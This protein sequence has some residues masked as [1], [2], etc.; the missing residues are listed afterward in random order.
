MHDVLRT[1]RL[2]GFT[3]LSLVACGGDDDPGDGGGDGSS[4]GSTTTGTTGLSMTDTS[5]ASASAEGDTTTGDESSGTTDE[6][7]SSSGEPTG[8]KADGETCLSSSECVSG[9]CF[10]I[11]VG[12][13]CGECTDSSDCDGGGCSPA[14]PFVTPPTPSF[15]NELLAGD[16]CDEMVT[17]SGDLSCIE[18]LDVPNVATISTCSECET[19]DDC[20]GD[21][22]CAPQFDLAQFQGQQT[23]V[24]AGS[25]ELN[26]GCEPGRDETCSSGVCSVFALPPVNPQLEVGVCGEC[27]GDNPCETGQRCAPPDLLGTTDDPELVG[28]RCVDE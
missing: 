15:C 28:S 7:G 18:V 13:V 5:A 3:L 10:I 16:P 17:C 21:D 6:G 24:A 12:G 2:I 14:N 9:N 20:S 23:C 25:V 27:D 22:I 4:S 19:D 8:D 26:Q 1:S 11:G